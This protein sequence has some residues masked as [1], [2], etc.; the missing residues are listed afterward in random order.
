MIESQGVDY[1]EKPM[2]FLLTVPFL[3]VASFIPSQDNNRAVVLV[4]HN[5][6]LYSLLIGPGKSP[7]PK[8]HQECFLWNLKFRV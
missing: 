7:G 8:I 4:Q 6:T 2:R 3:E 5:L 1:S